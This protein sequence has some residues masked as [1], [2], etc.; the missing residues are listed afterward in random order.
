MA[1]PAALQTFKREA[2]TDRMES[3]SAGRVDD[4]AAPLPP[5]PAPQAAVRA[6]IA[7]SR[8][9]KIKR[10]LP[11]L[12]ATLRR[13]RFAHRELDLP[14]F[15]NHFQQVARRLAVAPLVRTSSVEVT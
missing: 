7:R 5:R 6:A 9:L 13:H 8:P 12:I 14:I 3:I 11:S 10:S 1:A 4:D 15:S 2:L